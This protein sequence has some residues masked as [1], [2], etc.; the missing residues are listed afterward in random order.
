MKSLENRDLQ[1]CFTSDIYP[2]PFKTIMPG[3]ILG[4]WTKHS[5]VRSGSNRVY[6]PNMDNFF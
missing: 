4:L 6:S 5:S 2:H 1:T 3:D